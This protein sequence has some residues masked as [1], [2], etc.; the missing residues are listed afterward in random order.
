M[1]TD[2]CS[3]QQP[4]HWLG[5]QAFSCKDIAVIKVDTGIIAHSNLLKRIVCFSGEC[6][7]Q[8]VSR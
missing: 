8:C 5:L 7:E 3:K 4:V 1:S 6:Y 2:Q